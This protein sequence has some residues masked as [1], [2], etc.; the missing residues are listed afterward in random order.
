MTPLGVLGSPGG[1]FG[2]LGVSGGARRVIGDPWEVP[3]SSGEVPGA[4]RCNSWSGLGRFWGP[5]G[6]TVAKKV[7]TLK[8]SRGF[9]SKKDVKRYPQGIN[10]GN[11]NRDKIASKFEC[12]SSCVFVVFLAGK[13]E[14]M[15]HGVDGSKG[16]PKEGSF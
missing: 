8:R 15:D 10:F 12:D 2:S 6:R 9:I 14:F 7:A 16:L 3:G 5:L 11:Q 1:H 4:P 13:T